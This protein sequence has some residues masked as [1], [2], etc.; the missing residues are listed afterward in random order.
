MTRFPQPRAAKSL[1]S[2][3]PALMPIGELAKRAGIAASALRFYEEQQLLHSQRSDGG[4]RLYRRA[5][6]RRVA[7]IRVAQT[8]GL[9]LNEIRAA[10]ASLPESR[11][12]TAADWNRLSRQW[13]PLLDAR[14]AAMMRLRD[15]L[16]SCIGCG[17]LSM[18]KCGLYNPADIA[19]AE[20]PGPR[21]LLRDTGDCSAD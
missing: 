18:K 14:I 2:K 15:Q 1:P 9:S 13:R 17:C 3:D 10:L 11:T 4:R 19:A 5:D 16:D 7:F 12:P 8:L 21:Y 6:L 20:G